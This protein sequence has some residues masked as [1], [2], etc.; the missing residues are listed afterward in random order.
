MKKLL[1][2]GVLS[3]SLNSVVHSALLVNGSFEDPVQLYPGNNTG[4][5]GIGWTLVTLDGVSHNVIRTDGSG[6]G[7]GPDSAFDATQYYD[8]T[9]GSG[10][11][12]QSFTVGADSEVAFGAAFSRRD[13]LSMANASVGIYDSTNTTLVL[14]STPVSISNEESQEIWKSSLGTGI[15]TVGTYVIRLNMENA[16]NADAAFV[17]VVNV[18]P[19]PTAALLGAMGLLTLLRRRR[20]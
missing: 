20:H 13:N 2:A 14:S 6:Y 17:N 3:I 10:Y 19:E 4:A 5:T 8:I 11:I 12:W 1:I 7:G 16:A 15:L 18:V 9:N